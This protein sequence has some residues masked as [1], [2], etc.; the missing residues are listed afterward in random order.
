MPRN[1][2]KWVGVDDL[3]EPAGDCELCGTSIRYV[4]AIEHHS[5]GA[6][7][8]GCDCCD[9]LTQSSEASEHHRTYLKKVDA[10]KRFVSSKRWKTAS[11]GSLFILQERLNFQIRRD[12][13]G[14]FIVLERIAGRGRF[15]MLIEAKMK[16]FDLI[17]SGEARAF[18]LRCQSRFKKP[19]PAVSLSEL[20]RRLF[21][22]VR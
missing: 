4:Y 1:D 10:R 13:A 20:E 9:K 14:H 16:V 22:K 3:G 18:I 12:E 19:T 8:V 21:G 17:Q 7:A 6:M 11:D 15:D 5:W 2:W